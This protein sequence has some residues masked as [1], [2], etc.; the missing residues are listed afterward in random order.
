MEAGL[1]SPPTDTSSFSVG[2]LVKTV[3]DPTG[4]VRML[5]FLWLRDHISEPKIEHSQKIFDVSFLNSCQACN[6]V[7]SKAKFLS[8]NCDMFVP[9]Y[10][11]FPKPKEPNE[12]EGTDFRT[13][14]T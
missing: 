8:Y 10:T 11:H 5:P 4:A 13:Q 14:E 1:N 6:I 12:V 2:S 3:N 7:C 9:K